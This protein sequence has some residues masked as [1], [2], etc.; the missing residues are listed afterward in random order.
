MVTTY[1]MLYSI[2]TVYVFKFRNLIL[3]ILPNFYEMWQIINR[4]VFT[5]LAQHVHKLISR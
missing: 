5:A 2:H 1:Y 3:D 4:K